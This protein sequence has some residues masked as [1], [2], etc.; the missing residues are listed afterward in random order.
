METHPAATPRAQPDEG[1]AL[2]FTTMRDCSDWFSAG[3]FSPCRGTDATPAR[4]A[5]VQLFPQG[6]AVNPE[7]VRLTFSQAMIVPAEKRLEDAARISCGAPEPQGSGVWLDDRTWVL[8]VFSRP[9]RA[10]GVAR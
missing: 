10:D 8:H 3:S 6:D 1:P 9:S 2:C 7:Q 5:G 4:G